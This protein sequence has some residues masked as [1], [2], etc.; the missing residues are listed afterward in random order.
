MN[1][2][3]NKIIQPKGRPMLQWVGKKPLEKVEYFPAQACEQVGV[4]TL[5]DE[6]SYGSFCAQNYNLLFHGDNI[7]VLSFLISAGY[8]DKIDLIYID[9]PFDSGADYVRQ[10]SLRKTTGSNKLEGR[11]YSEIEQLQYEDIWSNDT[12]LQF[13]YERLILLRQLLSNKGSLY[14]HC[15]WHKSHFLRILLD[16]IFGS[17]RFVNEIIWNYKGTTNS[18]RSFAKKHDTIFVYS[19]TDDYIFNADDMRVPYE[20]EGKFKKDEDGRYWMQWDRSRRY[21]PKQELDEF[22]EYKLLGK[23]QYDVWDDIPSMATAHG[24]EKVD[25]PTQ[26]PIELLKRIISASTDSNSIVLDCFSGSGTTAI[27]AGELSRRWIV[28]DINMGAIQ[29]TKKR[30]L[31]TFCDSEDSNDS[32]LK[33]VHYGINYYDYSKQS[34]LKRIIVQRYGIK[35]VRSDLYFDGGY[36]SQL[37]KIID[38]DRPMTLI[39]IQGIDDEIKSRAD[40]S[41]DI[42]VFCNGVHLEVLKEL[43]TRKNP[44]NRI[45]VCDIQMDGIVTHRPAE[46]EIKIQKKDLKVIIEVENY[47]SNDILA[48]LDIHRTLFDEH[49]DDFRSQIDYILIDADYDGNNFSISHSDIPERK[50]D[51]VDGKYEFEMAR[52]DPIIAVKIVDMLGEETIFVE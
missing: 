24:K 8:R 11:G 20:D 16:E 12:Y 33:F 51:L 45:I 41:R 48:K 19:K 44:V 17:H 28:A 22:G 42:V 4:T 43:E 52:E 5:P 9:P 32:R 37:A 27:A 29:E 46:V 2:Q 14:L 49:I 25:Y 50:N 21:Y 35:P 36:G 13:M 34:E 31:N 15:D 47:V 39:D 26:K 18:S 30:L 23:Y 7:E 10:V 1:S 38:L 40:D 6:P 3:K